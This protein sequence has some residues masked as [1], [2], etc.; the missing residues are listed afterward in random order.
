[1]EKVEEKKNILEMNE[2]N[3]NRKEMWN[4]EKDQRKC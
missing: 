1:M 4:I 3:R 2:K